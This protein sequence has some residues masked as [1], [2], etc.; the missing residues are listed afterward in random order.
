MPLPALRLSTPDDV[1]AIHAVWRAAVDAT[2]GFVAPADL[3]F[4]ENLLLTLYLPQ[5]PV[6]LATLEDGTATG[7]MGLTGPKIDALFVHPAFHRT[8][9][10]RRLIDHAASL[11]AQ[12]LVDVNAQNPGA[13]TFYRTLGFRVVGRS[14]IDH[15]GKPY[16]LIFMARV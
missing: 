16:P 5:V 6:W 2:H 8:G 3:D 11:H 15:G 4:Y 13:V 1:A 10:G 12:L 14:P 9:V 7:F